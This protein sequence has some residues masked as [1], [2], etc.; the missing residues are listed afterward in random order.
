MKENNMKN[1]IIIISLAMM[2]G[3]TVYEGTYSS[4]SHNCELMERGQHCLSDHSC[5]ESRDHSTE[6]Y[7]HDDLPY[8]GFHNN[9]YYYYGV[10][11][12]YPW[13]YWYTL[14]PPY[15]YSTHTHVSIQ[16]NNSRIV[17]NPRAS[18]FNNGKGRSYKPN[19]PVVRNVKTNTNRNNV[20]INTNRNNVKVNTNR[21]NVKTNTNRNNINRSNNKV[22]INKTIINRSNNRKVN[23]K[24]PR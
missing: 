16:L 14:L 2:S 18:K 20:R 23:T 19:R 10:P 1:L 8:W 4:Q 11:H 5:C 21:I 12:L 15:T 13:W 9:F 3:C 7:Y 17:R 6:I 24:R 22:R